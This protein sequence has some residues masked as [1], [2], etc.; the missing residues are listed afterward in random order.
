MGEF[1]R[2]SLLGG[3]CKREVIRGSLLSVEIV[4]VLVTTPTT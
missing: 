2:G 3:V 1:M 4:P